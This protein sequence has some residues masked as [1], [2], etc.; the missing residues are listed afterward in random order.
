MR[1]FLFLSFLFTGISV[2][3]QT[4]PTMIRLEK[5]PCFGVC[6]AYR[7]DY[8]SNGRVVFKGIKDAVYDGTIQGQLPKAEWNR[9]I[10]RYRKIAWKNLPSAYKVKSYDV[11]KTHLT[12]TVGGKTYRVRNADDGPE[13]LQRLGQDLQALWAKKVVWNKKSFVPNPPPLDTVGPNLVY[14]DSTSEP[15]VVDVTV[16][17]S[18]DEVY[19]F[20]EQMPEFPGGMDAMLSFIRDGIR[21]PAM[22]K[23]AGV[24]GKVICQFVIDQ[25]GRI[26]QVKVLRGIG[27]G[28]DEEALRVI[29]SMPAWKPGRQNGQPVRVQY[30]LPIAFK[31]Q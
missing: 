10:S 6:P 20:V 31:L 22:A 16:T 19:A 5:T 1:I 9:L 7:V 12:I 4:L 13:T 11:S 8:Y 26:S 24:Q 3:G 17:N 21:Y 14:I 30:N 18:Q 23:E 27:Y 28:C 15:D 29:R 2:F 25:D